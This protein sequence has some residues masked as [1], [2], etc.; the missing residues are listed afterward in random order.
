MSRVDE[1]AA[2][3]IAYRF[4]EQHR[5]N[6]FPEGVVR[7]DKFLIVKVNIGITSKE[8]RYVKIDDQTGR[9]IEYT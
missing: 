6:V 3:N 1:A 7:K 5:S 2:M 4:F 8:T 9:I